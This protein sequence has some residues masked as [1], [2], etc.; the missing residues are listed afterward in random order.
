MVGMGVFQQI[1]PSNSRISHRY[2]SSMS[3][4][5]LESEILKGHR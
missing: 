5:A 2:R 4:F 3:S 1:V